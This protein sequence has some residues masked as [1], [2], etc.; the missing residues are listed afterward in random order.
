MCLSLQEDYALLN[1]ERDREVK[2]A[3][4]SSKREFDALKSEVRACA[5]LV[6]RGWDLF[7]QCNRA[8]SA[9]GNPMLRL[10]LHAH[11]LQFSFKENEV[12]ELEGKRNALQRQVSACVGDPIQLLRSPSSSQSGLCH[13]CR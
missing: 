4:N 8:V 6:G 7:S 1:F 9:P 12:Q 2:D 10:Y 5:L 11:H 3:R 13:A